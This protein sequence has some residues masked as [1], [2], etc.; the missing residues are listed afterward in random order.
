MRGL[1]LRDSGPV[2]A[3]LVKLWETSLYIFKQILE[4]IICVPEFGQ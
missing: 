4:M 1:L 3:A 2:T